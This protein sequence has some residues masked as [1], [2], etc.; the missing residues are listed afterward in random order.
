MSE[1]D[2]S[3]NFPVLVRNVEQA[4]DAILA[5]EGKPPIYQ[6]DSET[7]K[8]DPES[9]FCSFCGKG[10]NQVRQM[11]QCNSAYIC[12]Q[13]VALCHEIIA[14]SMEQSEP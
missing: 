1:N 6:Q 4:I 11:L 8:S 13:C 10:K 3:D 14:N 12:N 7:S 5:V 9:P 2:K